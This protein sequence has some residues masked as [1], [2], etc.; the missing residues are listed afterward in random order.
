MVT[1]PPFVYMFS[2]SVLVLLIDSFYCSSVVRLSFVAFL[3]FDSFCMTIQCLII[4]LFSV[5]F[6]SD[7]GIIFKEF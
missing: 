4:R 1:T 3:L 2:E 7:T 5:F 6:H